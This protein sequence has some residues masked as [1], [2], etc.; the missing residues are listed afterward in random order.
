MFNLSD[1]MLKE[2]I[3]NLY[4]VSSGL[5][6]AQYVSAGSNMHRY[7]AQNHCVPNGKKMSMV[8]LEQ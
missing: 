2:K 8:H 7:K 3:K 6:G 1:I 5:N 4:T